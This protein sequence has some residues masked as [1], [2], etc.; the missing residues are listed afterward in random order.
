MRFIPAVSR[1]QIPLPLFFC[2]L[3]WGIIVFQG[4]WRHCA[5][6]LFDAWATSGILPTAGGAAENFILTIESPPRL[7]YPFLPVSSGRIDL[8]HHFQAEKKTA[9]QGRLC[10]W[11]PQ[12]AGIPAERENMKKEKKHWAHKALSIVGI[13]LL[14]LLT[15]VLVVN[16][17]MI[18]QSYT[19]P[20]RV[21]D[22]F[23]VT[24]MIVVTD[25]MT[26]T[27]SSGDMIVSR[28]TPAEEI[29]VGD[30]ISF[31]DPLKAKNTSIIT[32]RVVEIREDE[33]G[34]LSFRTKGDGNN[35][36][37]EVA[38]PASNI[39]GVYKLTIPFAGQAA[40]FLRTGPGILFCI[41]I[42]SLVFIGYEL[43]RRHLYEKQ[44]KKLL[45]EKGI[46]TEYVSAAIH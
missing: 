18:V 7:P 33:E 36:A 28:K 15:P 40:L 22:L 43:I 11:E 42:P 10:P 24:P 6:G 12:N 14:A 46:A 16:I 1:V 32:H 5:P 23:G 13:V 39:V 8:S 41:V 45:A 30:V 4:S 27:I 44:V 25:S 34:E 29:E 19:D 17:V 2:A 38:V 37:D 9:P 21:P 3:F 26:P 31:F 35:T 20:D